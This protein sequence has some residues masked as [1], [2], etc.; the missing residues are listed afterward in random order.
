MSLPIIVPP[1]EGSGGDKSFSRAVTFS[2]LEIHVDP[3]TRDRIFIIHSDDAPKIEL[4]VSPMELTLI[5][6]RLALTIARSLH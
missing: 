5:L 4:R 1:P 2:A 6:A 3:D